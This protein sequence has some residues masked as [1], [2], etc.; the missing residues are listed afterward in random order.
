MAGYNS[1]SLH[2]CLKCAEQNVISEKIL[3][4]ATYRYTPFHLHILMMFQHEPNIYYR[5]SFHRFA[6]QNSEN[7]SSILRYSDRSF[8]HTDS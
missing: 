2:P 1:S 4:N 3:Q 8:T 6:F 5:N 7:T